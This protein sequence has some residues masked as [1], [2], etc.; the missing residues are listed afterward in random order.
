M[1]VCVCVYY[2]ITMMNPEINRAQNYVR[3]NFVSF[4]D[5]NDEA[6]YIYIYRD[7]KK[8]TYILQ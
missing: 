7:G 5:D 1:Y 2:V 3:E 4:C 8:Y 6:D